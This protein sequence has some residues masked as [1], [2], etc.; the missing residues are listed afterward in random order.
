MRRFTKTWLA[1]LLGV[2]MALPTGCGDKACVHNVG[3]WE[4]ITPATCETTGV[5]QGICGNCYETVQESIPADPTA[6][7]YGEWQVQ[8]PTETEEGVAVKT[9]TVNGAH[10]LS[11]TLPVLGS[12]EYDSEITTRPSPATD[13]VRTYVLEHDNGDIQFTQPIPK[14]GIQSVRDAVELGVAAESKALIRNARGEMGFRYYNEQNELTEWDAVHT[15]AYE[16][17][18]DYTH[19]ENG[20]DDCDLWY[21]KD[22]QGKVYGLTDRNGGGKIVNDLLE[23]SSSEKYLDGSRFYFQYAQDL[24]YYYG[25]EAL[26]DGIYTEARWSDNG[27]FE[28][29]VET[30]GQ[31]NTTY[32][33][34]FGHRVN[35]GG[36][37]G[38]FTC[39]NVRFGLT[40]SY[41]IAWVDMLGTTYVNNFAQAEPVETW[42]IDEQTGNAVVI[43]GKENG[44]RYENII[45]MNQTLKAPEDVV[46]TN[47]HTK[48]KIF[49]SSFD[50]LYNGAVLQEGE[51]A[52]FASG[53]KTDYLFAITNVQP[54]S[55]LE[56]YSFDNFSFY[57]RTQG[58]YGKEVDIPINYGT[59][60]SAGMAV[61]V[62]AEK[63]FFLNAQRAGE[64]KVVVKT[65]NG[66]ERIIDCVISQDEPSALRPSVYE[67]ADGAYLWNTSANTTL[68]I[69]AYTNQPVYVTAQV[70][71]GEK[72]YA[73]AS[74]KVSVSPIADEDKIEQMVCTKTGCGFHSPD[75]TQTVCPT[76]GSALKTEFLADNRLTATA[77]SSNMVAVTQFVSSKAGTYKIT[78][79]SNLNTAKKCTVTVTVK[80][81]PTFAELTAKEYTGQIRYQN[82]KVQATVS[83]SEVT[84]SADKAT[85]TAKA[86]IATEK[87]TG[88][89]NCT[90]NVADR[91]LSSEYLSGVDF[92]VKLALNEAYDFVA[93]IFRADIAVEENV[94]L[95]A[96]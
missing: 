39:V 89:L 55:A 64:Q 20:T 57:L 54:A 17:G 24:G 19:I 15:H 72:N 16:I 11:E 28:E 92:S 13:G 32:G 61:N 4:T 76:C 45:K 58:E 26:L 23:A 9:C 25:V 59:M 44:T 8:T 29:T 68:S 27:D 82:A 81:A 84:E 2:G 38:Y 21:F 12:L 66:V 48:D 90:Y 33:F 51:K 93:K 37:S 22:E 63:E 43:D 77:V 75:L 95:S 79:T 62:N 91:E 87:G 14:T 1:L 42:K 34:S 50:I 71:E 67:Y 80:E 83:F 88:V 31:G 56:N 52:Y 65:A 78:M 47:P 40:E 96:K 35:S 3:T 73:S 5:K 6:H 74:H 41:T 69:T 85:W 18:E 70:P 49:I 46:P 60:L 7:V 10:T 30:D 86:T 53:E 36:D 94:V